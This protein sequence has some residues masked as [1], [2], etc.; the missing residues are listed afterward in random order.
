[1]T[2]RSRAACLDVL[3]SS[4]VAWRGLAPPSWEHGLHACP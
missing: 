1:M 4:Q 2:W 3:A